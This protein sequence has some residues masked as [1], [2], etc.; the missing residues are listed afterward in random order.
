[1]ENKSK[2]KVI[3]GM[4][5]AL[6][7]VGVIILG[8][9][10]DYL[11]ALKFNGIKQGTTIKD[12]VK[13]TTKP[14]ETSTPTTYMIVDTESSVY[15]IAYPGYELIGAWFVNYE[16]DGQPCADYTF[17]TLSFD[18][19]LQS[20]NDLFEDVR[21]SVNT[22]DDYLAEQIANDEYISPTS[23]DLGRFSGSEFLAAFDNTE[24]QQY[25]LYLYGVLKEGVDLSSYTDD[26]EKEIYMTNTCVSPLGLGDTYYFT[27][28]DTYGQNKYFDTDTL[29]T[30][31]GIPGGMDFTD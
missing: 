30:G 1:M 21:L 16:N 31:Y 24:S 11:G 23:S 20:L 22:G 2:K 3:I 12:T 18:L 14:S 6:L 29:G 28:S 5:I 17:K 15:N 27:D 4:V 7:L 9:S 13:N 8:T 26:K 10:T 19:G 25:L